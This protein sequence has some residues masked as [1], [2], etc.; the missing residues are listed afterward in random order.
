MEHPNAEKHLRLSLAKSSIR[1]VGSIA[2]IISF[3]MPSAAIIILAATYG[4]AEIVGIIEE[5]V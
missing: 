3:G 2:A 5:I 1:I 4:I